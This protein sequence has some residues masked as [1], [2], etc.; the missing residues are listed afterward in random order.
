VKV[1]AVRSLFG[2]SNSSSLVLLPIHTTR[3]RAEVVFAAYTESQ[4][5]EQS[6][7]IYIS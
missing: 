3:F 4:H 2:S 5:F 7:Y 1:A 6:I